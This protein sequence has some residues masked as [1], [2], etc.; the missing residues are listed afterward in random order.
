MIHDKQNALYLKRSLL[1]KWN[2]L[3]QKWACRAGD[4]VVKR[5]AY[6]IVVIFTAYKQL[7]TTV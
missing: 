1:P 7:C 6:G 2:A 3:V 4:K 5:Q